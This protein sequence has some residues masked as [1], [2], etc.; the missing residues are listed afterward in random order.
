[1]AAVRH[2]RSASHD[3]ARLHEKWQ[4]WSPLPQNVTPTPPGAGAG[5]SEWSV[6][7]IVQTR[8]VCPG[9][10]TTQRIRGPHCASVEHW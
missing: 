1:M 2:E 6:H 4:T 9:H 7:V 5:H 3:P 8:S 10:T